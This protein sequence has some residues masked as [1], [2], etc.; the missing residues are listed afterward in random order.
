MALAIAS[1][2]YFL[3]FASIS[4]MGQTKQ[5]TGIELAVGATVREPTPMGTREQRFAGESFIAVALACTIIGVVAALGTG[6]AA[7]KVAAA[8]AAAAAVCLLIA[9]ST[10]ASRI[11]DEGEGLLRL[12]F[13]PGYWL[14]LSGCVAGLIASLSVRADPKLL[15]RHGAGP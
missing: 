6:D 3:P 15:S 14:A 4:C 11:R 1:A 13:S 12:E 9:Q 7:R 8:A 2:A 10:L 5:F